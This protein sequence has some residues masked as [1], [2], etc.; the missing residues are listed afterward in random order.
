[1]A[2]PQPVPPDPVTIAVRPL[3]IIV[4]I[5]NAARRTASEVNHGNFAVLDHP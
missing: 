4:Q 5:Y 1:M 3:R 2:R